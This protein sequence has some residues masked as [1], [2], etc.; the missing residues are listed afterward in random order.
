MIFHLQK[1]FYDTNKCFIPHI[2][3]VHRW[4]ISYVRYEWIERWCMDDITRMNKKNKWKK[5]VESLVLELKD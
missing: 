2:F 5:T 3:I 1:Q 4:N